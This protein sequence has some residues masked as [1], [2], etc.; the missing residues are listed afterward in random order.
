MSDENY[1][2]SVVEG[3]DVTIRWDF[4]VTADRRIQAN[5]PYII[6]KEKKMFSH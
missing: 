6:I 5:R 2:E 3:V 1:L 4:S